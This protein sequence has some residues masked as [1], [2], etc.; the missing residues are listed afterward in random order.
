MLDS[1]NNQEKIIF[2]DGSIGILKIPSINVK[3]PI[4]DGTEQ[5]ILKYT[6]RT[7]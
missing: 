7:F 6:I 4:F 5:E 3:G 1:E 2:E